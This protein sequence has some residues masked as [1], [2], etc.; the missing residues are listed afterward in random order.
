MIELPVSVGNGTATGKP[1]DGRT[2]AA[3]AE[4]G[5]DAKAKTNGIA[6]QYDAKTSLTYDGF[7]IVIQ[8]ATLDRLI[9]RQ[10]ASMSP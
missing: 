6:V 1:D 4:A 9:D 2:A 7:S 8:R 10:G 5:K 3:I